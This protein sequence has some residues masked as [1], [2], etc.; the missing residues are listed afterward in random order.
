[1]IASVG[2]AGLLQSF[3]TPSLLQMVGPH[4]VFAT[5]RL[6]VIITERER[7]RERNRQTER[8]R[9][10]QTGRQR[11]TERDTERETDRDREGE[12]DRQTET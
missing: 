5:Y 9:D 4:V 3:G 2:I 12:T 11:H 8:D 10:R 7:G 1:M 6:N